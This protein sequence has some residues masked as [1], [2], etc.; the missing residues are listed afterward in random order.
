MKLKHI[1]VIEI[2]L[3]IAAIAVFIYN[4]SMQREIAYIASIVAVCGTIAFLI[5]DIAKLR[6]N[7]WANSNLTK[8]CDCM[9]HDMKKRIRDIVIAVVVLAIIC[10]VFW[11]IA[12]I[13]S[14]KEVAFLY[15][16]LAIVIAISVITDVVKKRLKK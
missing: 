3:V 15:A 9:K 6:K 12:W 13:S 5:K 10:F 2:L 4:F 8:E 11:N 16:I 14:W 1:I 7:K